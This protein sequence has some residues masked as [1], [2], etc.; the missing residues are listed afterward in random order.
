MKTLI[1]VVSALFFCSTVWAAPGVQGDPCQNPMGAHNFAKVAIS[2]ATTTL[3][4][5]AQPSVGGAAAAAVDLCGGLLVATGTTP[6]VQFACG[7]Q[8]TNPCD[9]GQTTITGAMAPTA[10][11]PM[12]LPGDYTDFA[13][14][15]GQQLCLITGGTPNVQGWI[16]WS[17][18]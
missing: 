6:T 12:S 15:A 3:L 9:T 14:P 13:C 4:V 11:T 18:Q 5:A 2:S 8:V 7:T 17:P 16:T 1:L 10:G